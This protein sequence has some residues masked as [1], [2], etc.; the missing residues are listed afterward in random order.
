[1]EIGETVYAPCDEMFDKSLGGNGTNK[2]L[3]FFTKLPKAF[4]EN[5]C[6]NP[7]FHILE[8]MYKEIIFYYEG[9]SLRSNV[10]EFGFAGRSF[11]VPS[12]SKHVETALDIVCYEMSDEPIQ[13]G[14]ELWMDFIAAQ[15]S[16]IE[17]RKAHHGHITGTHSRVG[18]DQTHPVLTQ[19]HIEEIANE[20]FAELIWCEVN[21]KTE[22]Q[23][24][25]MLLNVKP[26]FLQDV[27][28]N[29][30]GMNIVMRKLTLVGNPKQA[31]SI[32]GKASSLIK[33]MYATIDLNHLK[34]DTLKSYS[35]L[36]RFL[37]DKPN[38]INSLNFNPF[39]GEEKPEGK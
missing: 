12:V 22:L 3:I 28:S 27:S 10:K 5:G 26:V 9:P 20:Q 36:T 31:P 17:Y 25:V 6:P 29:D 7:L 23:K 4:A 34:A 24:A 16:R 1:M 11:N 37:A 15:G 19:L 39:L 32:T 35:P 38:P 2:Q 18:I 8:R 30:P 21:H 33:E 13:K 14:T